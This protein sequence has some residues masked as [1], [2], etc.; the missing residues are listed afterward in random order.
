M[1]GFESGELL[2]ESDDERYFV[3]FVMGKVEVSNNLEK[4]WVKYVRLVRGKKYF[5]IFYSSVSN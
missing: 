1:L 3:E 4:V 5:Y 2:F